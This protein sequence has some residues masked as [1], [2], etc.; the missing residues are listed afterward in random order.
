M[1]PNSDNIFEIFGYTKQ[2]VLLLISHM[3]DGLKNQR[4]VAGW[5]ISMQWILADIPLGRN[6][7]RVRMIKNMTQE[8]IVAKM[9]LRGSTISRSTLANIET[10]RRNI[11]ASDLKLLKLILDVNYDEFFEDKNAGI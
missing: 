3:K 4:F 11:K 8:Q 10:G 7:R 1:S 9:Q 5:G 6:I 2:N